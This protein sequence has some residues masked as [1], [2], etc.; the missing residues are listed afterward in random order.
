MEALL[1][2]AKILCLHCK[3]FI[4]A[5]LFHIGEA[6]ISHS[7]SE[8]FIGGGKSA[9]LWD[10]KRSFSVKRREI[11]KI[12]RL[13]GIFSVFDEYIIVMDDLILMGAPVKERLTEELKNRCKEMKNRG[14]VPR[15]GLFRMGEKADDL[16][17]ERSVVKFMEHIGAEVVVSAL[18]ADAPK[19]LAEL[20][21]FDLYSK[22]D[23]DGVLPLMPLPEAC[24]PLV[25]RML[26]EK[27][28]DGLL[29]EKSPFSPCTPEAAVALADHYGL[30]A[31][32]TKVAVL[33][34]SPLV[35]KPLAELL[36]AR[37]LDVT[38]VHSQTEDPF[39]AV[40]RAD[41]VFSAVGKPRFLDE[42]YLRAGQAVIDIGICDDGN[43]G[44]CGD[45]DT[46]TAE[47]LKIRYSPVPGGVGAITTAILGSHV[48][49]SCE[50][51]RC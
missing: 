48:V 29:G 44:I 27:D 21:F 41:V 40:K 28:V 37:G 12:L 32:G 1:R 17:Y 6:D 3:H 2:N 10:E 43:G 35:G 24:M 31:N 22:R 34:R 33:G 42:R 13:W 45:L 39:S 36:K 25:E 14:I 18:G 11:K 50:D 47:A 30:L 16:S 9:A 49:C 7:R 23:M 38:V 8:Y 20:V 19:P 4:G 46:E 51:R 15:L 26:P 5:S